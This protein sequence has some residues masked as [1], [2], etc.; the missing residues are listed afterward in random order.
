MNE[1]LFSKDNSSALKGVAIL[2]MVFAHLFS[3]TEFCNLSNPLLYIK[4]EP[5]IHYMIFAMNPVDFFMV[6][7]GYGLYFTFSQGRR[8]NKKRILKLYIHYWITLV[9]FVSIGFFVVGSDKYPGSCLDIIYNCIG[10]KNS[11]NHETWFLL[12]YTLLTLSSTKIFAVCDKFKPINVFILSF[13]IYFLVRLSSR[14]SSGLIESYQ[15]FKWIDS[16]LTLQ[17]PFILG[18]LLCKYW[19]YSAYKK[20]YILIFALFILFIGI[21]LLRY[22]YQSIFYP[23]YTVLFIM[24]F[25]LLH[26]FSWVDKVLIELGKRSTSIWFIHTYFCYYFFKDFIY[27]FK[28]PIIIFGVL[29]VISWL[30]AIVI[31]KINAVFQKI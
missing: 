6:L 4:G 21:I 11:Y 22:N 23:F 31:D 20:N 16:Y 24:C 25:S 28:Y 5:V 14:Y 17:F 3:R 8:N 7:S 15:I 13:G 29:M 10:W 9:I 2:F 12:P 18:M 19:D 30:C 27:S 26:R 1:R